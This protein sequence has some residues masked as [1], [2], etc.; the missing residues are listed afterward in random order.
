MGV[1]IS[2]LLCVRCHQGEPQNNVSLHPDQVKLV[3]AAAAFTGEANQMHSLVSSNPL[4]FLQLCRQR[5]IDRV[6][7]YHCTFTKQ[8][9]VDGQL[10]PQQETDVRFRSDPF[11]VDMTFTR[12]ARDA[13]RA[14][15]VAG[16]WY[17]SKG[18]PMA[19]VRPAG[20]IIKTFIPKIRQPIH[21]ARAQKES[22]RTIDQF[23]FEI[24][25][26]LILKYSIQAQAEGKL[27]LNYVGEG[28]VGGRPTYVI[29]RFLPYTGQEHP[30]P[31]RLLVI[32]IDQEHLLPTACLSYAD[33][34]GRDLLGSYV[35]TDIQLNPGYTDKD[36]DPEAIGF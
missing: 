21:G 2:A 19:W 7:D 30:Y 8:E 16:K 13:A 25:F 22:R 15:Y 18:D 3:A 23:G 34:D 1:L 17:D 29:E 6:R 5:C 27:D 20:A 12:N 35:Y 11:S 24:S 26:D 33:D 31:D 28:A 4:G 36:F 14:L 9:Q 10:R 32:H